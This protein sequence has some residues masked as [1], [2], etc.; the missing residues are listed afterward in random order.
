[1]EL[2]RN[3]R[4]PCSELEGGEGTARGSNVSRCLPL[5]DDEGTR[6]RDVD[7]RLVPQ[8]SDGPCEAEREG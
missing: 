7:A 3:R 1:M 8:T 2:L 6:G 4:E 5:K